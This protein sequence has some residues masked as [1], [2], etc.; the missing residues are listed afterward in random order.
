[1]PL[2]YDCIFVNI[3]LMKMLDRKIQLNQATK[4]K[5]SYKTA[6]CVHMVSLLY[7]TYMSAI[8]LRSCFP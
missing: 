7:W 2:P 6:T 8:K 5:C 1:M 3:H 4:S